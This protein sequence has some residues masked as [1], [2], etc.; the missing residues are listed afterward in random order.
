MIRATGAEPTSP[1]AQEEPRAYLVPEEVAALLRLS[2]KSVYRLAKTE[3]TLPVLRIGGSIRF[4]RERLERWL[5]DREQGP[6]RPRRLRVANDAKP[7]ES[8]TADPTG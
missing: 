4:P 1:A 7:N 8:A 6:G 3:P 5:R 2:V